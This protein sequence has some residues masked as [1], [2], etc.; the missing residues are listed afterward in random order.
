MSTIV[1]P[2]DMFP[3]GRY[4]V[5]MREPLF[6][7]RVLAR[8]RHPG[9]DS[10]CG[11]TV[12]DL[13]C[14]MCLVSVNGQK[15]PEG[16]FPVIDRLKGVPVADLQFLM[17]VF[18]SAFTVDEELAERA[19]ELGEQFRRSAA[20]TYVIP[21]EQMPSGKFSVTFTEAVMEDVMRLE[22]AYPGENA[23]GYAFEELVF[24]DSIVA[25]DGEPVKKPRDPVELIMDWPHLDAQFAYAVFLKV[26]YIDAQ[27]GR[28]GER[29]GKSLRSG[30]Y[31]AADSKPSSGSKRASSTSDSSKSASSTSDS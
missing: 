23:C 13:L 20:T 28:E 22:R 30:L 9:E 21:A 11:Y 26:C 7:D 25:I 19:K 24:A 18:L 8:R 14:A 29:L 1:I 6:R 5:E 3:S 10:R 15:V 17:S 2:R 27:R 4:D 12:Q 31:R 16:P